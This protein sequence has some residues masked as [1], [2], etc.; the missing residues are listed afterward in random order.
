[1]TTVLR[2]AHT[3]KRAYR[4]DSCRNPI[5]PGQR[6]ERLAVPPGDNDLGNL[7]W[8][9]FRQHTPPGACNWSEPGHVHTVTCLEC[10]Q[11]E[12]FKEP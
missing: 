10:D 2:T 3:A 5:H 7:G 9:R 12:L 6:Y 8:L 1:M 4:C 11:L